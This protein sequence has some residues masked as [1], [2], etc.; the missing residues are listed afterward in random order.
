MPAG[1]AQLRNSDESEDFFFDYEYYNYHLPPATEEEEEEAVATTD[2]RTTAEEGRQPVRVVQLNNTNDNDLANRDELVYVPDETPN[3]TTT[4][5]S[6][7]AATEEPAAAEPI[8]FAIHSDGAAATEPDADGA[9]AGDSDGFLPRHVVV[10]NSIKEYQAKLDSLIQK[11]RDVRDDHKIIAMDLISK[12][13][14]QLSRRIQQMP[15]VSAEVPRREG[16]RRRCSSSRGARRR[17]RQ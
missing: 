3:G 16:R 5:Q 1:R 14:S 7:P 15:A 10:D 13:N 2:R 11:Y 6:T 4:E 12:K 17:R 9:A 8:E